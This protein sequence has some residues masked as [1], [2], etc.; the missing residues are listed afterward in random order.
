MNS[1]NDDGI[2]LKLQCSVMI[3]GLSTPQHTTLTAREG[4]HVEDS[5]GGAGAGRLHSGGQVPSARWAGQSVSA[6]SALQH[7]K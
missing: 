5:G 3:R 2:S 7:S 4:D 6:V 1:R